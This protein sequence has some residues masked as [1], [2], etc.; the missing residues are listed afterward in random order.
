M[1]DNE[2]SFPC[3]IFSSWNPITTAWSSSNSDEN[4][5]L[6]LDLVINVNSETDSSVG[7]VILV[8]FQ[9]KDILL[10][11]SLKEEESVYMIAGHASILIIVNDI[12]KFRVELEDNNDVVKMFDTLSSLKLSSLQLHCLESFRRDMISEIAKKMFNGTM[13]V[14]GDIDDVES[15][16]K[17]LEL[18]T[19]QVL[20]ELVEGNPRLV[21]M[22][23]KLCVA[24]CVVND[25]EEQDK[26]DNLS[27]E[28]SFSLLSEHPSFS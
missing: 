19:K 24:A 26:S 10:R 12:N 16:N 20:E 9:D 22:K 23:E 5:K 7:D 14:D 3:N 11:L 21:H 18:T 13:K 2:N 1:E 4:A 28:E 17:D 25:E 27:L 8:M 6:R 15:V